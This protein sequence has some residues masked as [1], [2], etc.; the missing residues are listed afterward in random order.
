MTNTRSIQDLNQ[1]AAQAHQHLSLGKPELARPYID[2]LMRAAPSDRT[3]QMLATQLAVISYPTAL[4]RTPTTIEQSRGIPQEMIDIVVFHVDLPVAP[5]GIHQVTDY[6]AILR[7]AFSAASIKAPQ[8]RRLILTDEST[9][10]AADIGAHEIIRRP[11]DLN[12]IMYERLRLQIAYL[13]ERQAGRASIL[14]DTDVVTNRDPAEVFCRNFDIGLTWRQGFPDAP[15]NGGMIF[16]GPSSRGLD[17]LVEARHCYDRLAAD[18]A[19]TERFDKSLKAW[20]G[21]QFA[22]A[23]TAGYREFG[24]RTTDGLI[25]NET[26]VAFLPCDLFNVTLEATGSYNVDILKQKFFVHFK[27]NR[28]GMLSKYV[29]LIRSGQL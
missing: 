10:F 20:W 16:V 17:F 14:M 1:L 26:I 4:R 19:I 5:S 7:Q 15:F 28:K 3:V 8:A 6:Q 13:Q 24:Q 25:V 9:S 18:V 22:L 29:E 27:G 2:A 12:Q 21:D 11:M 23:L